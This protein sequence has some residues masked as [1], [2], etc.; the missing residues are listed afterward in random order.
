[1]ALVYPKR[2]LDTVPTIVVSIFFLIIML[3]FMVIA[4]S[5]APGWLLYRVIKMGKDD[6]FDETRENFFKFLAFWIFQVR[7]SDYQYQSPRQP[8]LCAVPSAVEYGRLPACMHV[9]H[10]KRRNELMT[11]MHM[12]HGPY[13][14]LVLISCRMSLFFCGVIMSCSSGSDSFDPVGQP[15]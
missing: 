5:C 11:R 9:P 15:L 3:F 10:Q 7:A 2:L 14:E 12:N 6:R 4:V 1:M 13:H 8:V